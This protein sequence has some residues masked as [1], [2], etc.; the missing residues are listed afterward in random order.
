MTTSKPVATNADSIFSAPISKLS[1]PIYSKINNVSS[2]Y[3]EVAGE[4]LIDASDNLEVSF[5]IPDGHVPSEIEKCF[6]CGYRVVFVFNNGDI[7]ITEKIEYEGKTVYEMTKLD[8]L[9]KIY[10]SEDVKEIVSSDSLFDNYI[11]L[12]MG[13]GYLYAY[14]V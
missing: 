13:D 11:Y 2:V 8:G 1:A 10:T 7:Y 3:S 4:S 12:L 14:E 5:P 6:S 9:S